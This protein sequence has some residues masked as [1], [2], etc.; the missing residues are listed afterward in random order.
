MAESRRPQG[1]GGLKGGAAAVLK[2]EAKPKRAEMLLV[3]EAVAFY[4]EL[5]RTPAIRHQRYWSV[6]W[7]A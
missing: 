6:C 3:A 7:A 4:W 1:G 5:Y 2:A